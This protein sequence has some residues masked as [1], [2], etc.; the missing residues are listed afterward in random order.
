MLDAST[1]TLFDELSVIVPAPIT[2]ENGVLC[3]EHVNEAPAHEVPEAAKKP[4]APQFT[5]AQ[6]AEIKE[7]RAAGITIVELA[8][9]YGAGKHRIRKILGPSLAYWEGREAKGMPQMAAGFKNTSSPYR[10]KA[11]RPSV[12][13]RTNTTSRSRNV[14]N[15]G[16]QSNNP[17]ASLF[18]CAECYQSS[19]GAYETGKPT[20]TSSGQARDRVNHSQKANRLDYHSNMG[21]SATPHAFPGRHK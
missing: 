13:A 10:Q 21:V 1:Q 6:I 2:V 9:H 20:I 15:H 17:L 11:S 8:A 4:K 16:P 5:P 18:K 14:I 19:G 7:F 3:W 12:S